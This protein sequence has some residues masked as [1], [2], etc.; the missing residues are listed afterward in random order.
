MPI[1]V[2]EK[3]VGKGK[4]NVKCYS[5]FAEFIYANEV[6][7]MMPP[8]QHTHKRQCQAQT[9]ERKRKIGGRERVGQREK[10]RS[11]VMNEI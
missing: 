2:P 3:G 9:R 10:K 5:K 4:H 11:Q 6:A 8:S 7:F 1:A